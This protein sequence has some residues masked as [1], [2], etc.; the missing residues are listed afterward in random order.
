LQNELAKRR[1]PEVLPPG[2]VR[3][4]LAD[5]A[6]AVSAKAIQ[7]W[8][9]FNPRQQLY[10]SVMFEADQAEG[11]SRPTRRKKAHIKR[12][13]GKRMATSPASQW[14]QLPTTAEVP[15]RFRTRLIAAAQ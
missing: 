11:C 7:T 4:T 10:L 1:C 2:R 12:R 8:A 5:T 14:R 9:E 13:S 6:T 3:E 15:G